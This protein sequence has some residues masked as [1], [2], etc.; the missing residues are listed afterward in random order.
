MRRRGVGSTLAASPTMV[1]SITVLIAVVAVF[2]AYNANSGLP[3]VP[4]YNLSAQVPNADSLVTG[5]EVRIGGVR[6]GLVEQITPEAQEDGSYLARLDMK[7]D[8]DANPIPVD[9]TI[10]IRARSALGLQYVEI[11]RGTADEGYAAGATIPLTAAVPEPV[12]LDDVLSTFDE[13]TRL[14]IQQNLTEFGSALAGRG[15]SLNSA[16]GKLPGTLEVLEPVARNLSAP[17]TR[18]ARFIDAL[19]ATAAEVAPVAAE[20]AQLFVSLDTT[21]GAFANVARPF[22]QETISETPETLDVGTEALPAIRPFLANSARLFAELRPGVDALATNSPA[23]ADALEIGAPVLRKAPGFNRQLAPTAEAL[24]S[25]NDDADARAGID[26]LRETSSILTP[27]VR[28]IAPAQTVCNYAAILFDNAQSLFSQGT[29]PGTWQR[30]QVIVPPQDSG[31]APLPNNEGSPSSA[32]ANGGN[33]ANF[34]HVNPYPNTAAPGQE[35]ECEAG[36]EPYIIGSQQLG[37][38]PGNQ[39][40]VT[41]DQGGTP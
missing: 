29:G 2:L 7:L 3:F 32:P 33:I 5:N 25:L 34:L 38:V 8:E 22:I 6:V 1:G 23:I 40:T 41:K 24:R 15:Q 9:S 36:N 17:S 19:A 18:L 28:F 39:G 13:P 12:A 26:R 27:T 37:N 11:V 16:L 21:F 31:G 10:L 14:A 20:Q 4:S 35:R 30:F